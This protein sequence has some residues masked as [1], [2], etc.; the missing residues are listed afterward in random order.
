LTTVIDTAAYWPQV[1]EAISCH[2][3]QL[4]GYQALKALPEEYHQQLWGTQR[5]YRVF[6]LVNGGRDLEDDLFAGLRDS[7]HPAAM[8]LALPALSSH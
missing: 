7:E 2:Q 3:T 4:P 8:T 1:W 6:S 5:F